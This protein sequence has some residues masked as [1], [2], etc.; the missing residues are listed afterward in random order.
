M[1]DRVILV[2]H[3]YRVLLEHVTDPA[4]PRLGTWWQLPDAA[5]TRVPGVR[6]GPCVWVAGTSRRRERIHVAWL[7][8]P[9]APRAQ[10]VSAASLG[11]RWWTLDELAHS[12]ERFVPAR[13]PLLMPAVVR[14]EY[15][16]APVPVD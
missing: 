14:G 16:A 4:A 3:A 11:D 15:G 1:R 5:A 12:D 10:A 6:L 8:D 9:A 13:L 7:D 2:D